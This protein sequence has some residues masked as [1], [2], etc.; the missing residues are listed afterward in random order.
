MTILVLYSMRVGLQPLDCEIPDG[1]LGM[2][3][4]KQVFERNLELC[5][6]N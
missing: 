4:S 5:T 1:Q 2:E 3:G 6:R